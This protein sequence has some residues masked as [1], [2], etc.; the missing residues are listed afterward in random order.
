MKRLT[1]DPSSLLNSYSLFDAQLSDR[2]LFVRLRRLNIDYSKTTILPCHIGG[3]TKF[4]NVHA[5]TYPQVEGQKH[6]NSWTLQY[7]I[8]EVEQIMS[9]I[10]EFP[11]L[12]NLEMAWTVHII[13]SCIIFKQTGSHSRIYVDTRTHTQKKKQQNQKGMNSQDT[14]RNREE[15]KRKSHIVVRPEKNSAKAIREKGGE[16][17]R[18]LDDTAMA[19]QQSNQSFFF[20]SFSL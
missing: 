4:I 14:D 5:K 16:G 11:L 6:K 3:K 17:Y 13:F 2:W 1:I 20:L 7:R 12:S 8:S 10:S 19:R 18:H 9:S 15:L